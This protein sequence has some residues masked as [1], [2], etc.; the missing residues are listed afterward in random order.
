[1]RGVGR[2]WNF[3]GQ[4]GKRVKAETVKLTATPATG[5]D[6]SDLDDAFYRSP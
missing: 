2:A 1:M 6:W 4:G 5:H 3:F